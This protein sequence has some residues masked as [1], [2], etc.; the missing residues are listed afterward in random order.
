MVS[1][2][3]VVDFVVF[4][5]FVA[6]A[7]HACE[8]FDLLGVLGASDDLLRR[9]LSERGHPRFLGGGSIVFCVHGNFGKVKP[10]SSRR[11]LTRKISGRIQTRRN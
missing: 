1:P 3:L 2:W 9:S 7:D 8:E 10:L 11:L 5:E 6:D 4:H